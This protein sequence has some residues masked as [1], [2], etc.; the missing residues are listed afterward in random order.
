MLIHTPK[1]WY[2]Q[3][4]KS[5]YLFCFTW[6]SANFSS[7]TKHW[8]FCLP[9]KFITA[10]IVIS[11]SFFA[12]ED[13]QYKLQKYLLFRVMFSSESLV[14]CMGYYYGSVV[15]DLMCT[16]VLRYSVG[17]SFGISN[18]EPTKKRFL[19]F[20]RQEIFPTHGFRYHVFGYDLD[21]TTVTEFRFLQRQV[22]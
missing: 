15:L 21:S 4:C 12:D 7:S 8:S 1:W 22:R 20:T 10:A 18:S 13:S 2:L 17:I 11:L 9:L 5:C 3:I 19:I 14:T 16:L 6:R